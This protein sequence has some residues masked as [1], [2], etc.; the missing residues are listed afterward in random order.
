VASADWARTLTSNA[1]IGSLLQGELSDGT[2]MPLRIDSIVQDPATGLWQYG[3]SALGTDGSA[4]PLCGTRSGE[5]VLA[6]P[7]SGRYD[8]SS[9]VH[10]ADGN[11]FT[12]ACENGAI[13]KCVL[14]GYRPWATGQEC[15]STGDCENQSLADWHATCVRMVRADYCGDGVSHT[16]DGTMIN[17][18]DELGIQLEGVTGWELEAEWTVGGAQ[19]IRH[20]RWL[21]AD[22]SSE[23]TDLD[24]IQQNCPERLA[25]SATHKNGPKSCELSKSN[26]LTEYGFS[27]S[28]ELRR[29]LRNESLQNQ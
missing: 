13:G 7:L 21:K 29:L 6:I 10:T 26:F 23:M 24:Y 19:C 18:W 1:F 16:R 17:F 15:R 20:T 22:L 5:P 14:W 4:S 12:F 11:L 9:G 27:V 28:S 25:A 2:T 8:L 3:V